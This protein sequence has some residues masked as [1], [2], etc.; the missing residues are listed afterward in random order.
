EI[1]CSCFHGFIDKDLINLVIPDVRRVLVTKPH[2]KTPY[3]LL[4]SRT[5][6]IGF[7]RPFNCPV[8]IFNTLDPLGKFDGKAYERFLAGYSVSSKAFRVFNSGT[9]IVQ[10]TLRINFL[11]NQPNVTGSGPTWLFDT[12]TLT[13]SMNYQPVV[14]GNQPN[15]SVGIQE[16]LDADPQNTYA[17]AVY[18]DKETENEV[19]VSLS[20][21]DKTKKHDEKEKREAKGKSHVDLSIGVRDLSD[22]FEEFSLNSSNRVNAVSAPVTAVRPNS[23][24]ITNSF[25]ADGPSNT[26]VSLSFEIGGKSS[27]CESR[28]TFLETSISVSP[29]PTTRVHKDHPVTQIIGDLSLTPQTRSMARMVKEKGG[30]TQIND[31]DFHTYLPKGKRAIGSKWVFRNKKD[32]RDIVVRN[33]ARLVAQ[34]H[35]QEEGIDYEEVFALVARIKVIRLFL[36]YASFMGFMVYQMD[37]KSAF[38]YETIEEEVYVYQPLEFEDPDYPDKVYNMVKA[39]YGLHQPH[40][41]WYKTLANYLLENGFQRGKIDQTLFIKRQKDGKSASTPI[42]TKKPLLKDS[43]GEDVNVHI[44]RYLKGKP[45]LGLWYPKDSPFN[46]VAYSNSDYAGASLDRKSTTGGCQF[47]GCILISWQCKKQT[48]VATSS[49]EAKYVAAISCCAQEITCSCFHGFIDKDLINLVIPD[50]RRVLVTKP[51]NKTPYELLLSRTPSIGFMRPFNCPVT[52]FNTLDPL[53]KFDGKAYERFLAGYS[54]SSKAFRVFNSGTKIVQKTLRINFLEN[55]PNVT[56]SGPTWLFDTDTLTQSMNYQPVVAGNQPNFSVGIQENLD[57]GKVG[58]ES[59]STQQYVLLPL[60]STGFK[61]PQNTYADAVYDD[62]ETENEVHVSLSSSDKTK[63]HDEK[64]KREAKGKSHV[65]LSIGVRDL[66]DKFEEF[67]LNSSNR[68][69]AVSAPVTAVRPNST[70]I[71]NSFIADGPSN[72]SVSLSFEIGGKSSFCESRL[73][74]LETSISVSPIPTTRVHKDHPVTQIIGD[75]SLT[76]Q[77]RSMARM[78]KEKGGLTQINDEDFHTYLPKGKRAIGSKW[79][80]RNKK[81]ERDIVVR[82]KARLVAQGHTQEEGID[83]EEVFALVARIKVIRLFLPYAS[84]MGFMVYQMDVKSAFLYETI[85]EEVYVYQ[86]LEFE[87]PDYPDKVYNMVKALYGLHQPH[88]AW[89]KTLANYLLENGFQR[90]KIDQT[91]FIKRQKDGKS[92]STPIDT[93]KPLLKDSDGEDV[94][95]HIYRYLK[96]KPHL[97]LWYPKDSPFNLV[98][99]SNSDYAGASLD[100][101]STTGELASPK[102]NGSCNKALAIPGQTTTGKES[103]KPF[104]ADRLP[105][106]ILLTKLIIT[107]VSSKLMLFGLTIDAAHLMLLGVDSPLVDGMLVPQQVPDVEDAAEDK[108]TNNEVSAEPT[109]PSPTP[110]IP[111]PSHTQE[112]NPS[113]PQAQTAQPSSPPLPPQPSQTTEISMTLL[114]T[115]LETCATLTKQVANLKQDKIAHAIEITKLKQMVK[116]RMHLNRGKI[117]E[118]D[119]DE[120]VTPVDVEVKDTNTAEPSE[121]E[122]VIE[123]V[124]TAKLITEVVTTPATPITAAQVP[125]ASAPRRKRGVIKQDP[126]ETSTV[127][128]IMHSKDK[129]KDKGKV[130]RKEKQDNTVMRYQALKRKPVTD[131]QERKNMMVYLKNIA[132]FDMDFFRGMTYGNRYHQKDKIKDKPNKTKHEMESVEKS[133][134]NQS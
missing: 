1:T 103:S 62:K 134:V 36:P 92:A 49:T 120:D 78:V 106:T 79:V 9:K 30:L 122:E 15:F 11:E 51:H 34:G 102:A 19:H 89:Y 124:T 50:V 42:D 123:V 66:S 125:K 5:P 76:P 95:V 45:H 130:K 21:S 118:L 56:G 52:I 55:Q 100:R 7:M 8:T 81:D 28:L 87:D 32:E 44:Y 26:S 13:Q 31:E 41:A 97:G 126:E 4:L 85:E 75:L 24:D 93:K 114:N 14:A 116:R 40:R 80:F 131:A 3:E 10:K 113:P 59:V 94:N 117:A 98:A 58:K 74:F 107:T 77:T 25:I 133:E 37:V 96:G 57:A 127:S 33:K 69:N 65:D 6:S 132:G 46:L 115:L 105:I 91:L 35:T 54:V 72:T 47:L 43:D 53:G 17:D 61:D 23:T 12:D 73:T 29:I 60:W 64:E 71:T 110:V 67:S 111:S 88:R 68:V 101:K 39:L 84:F 18:D 20:S 27:F 48:V 2:N 108:D 121:V 128:V 99:Y 129:S 70:D 109:P 112:H 90:G 38:L 63:K 16:N 83:Y 86:P 104:M 119:A 22:K 82:N